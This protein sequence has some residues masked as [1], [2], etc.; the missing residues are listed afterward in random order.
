MSDLRLYTVLA[1]HPTTGVMLDV[2]LIA[3]SE[4]YAISRT[5]GTLFYR[6]RDVE[7]LH[8]SFTVTDTQPIPNRQTPTAG[9][10]DDA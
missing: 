4:H 6:D 7:W 8:G 1:K 5:R 2:E 3:S 9:S 10:T